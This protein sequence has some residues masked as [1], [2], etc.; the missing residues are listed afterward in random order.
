LKRWVLV[1]LPFCL[2]RDQGRKDN[3]PHVIAFG[4]KISI[5]SNCY[6]WKGGCRGVLKTKKFVDK[7]YKRQG[8]LLSFLV[9]ENH[10]SYQ[11]PAF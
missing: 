4:L 7:L 11:F 3:F 10:F 8:E 6:Y 2:L 9:L 1:V 5:I